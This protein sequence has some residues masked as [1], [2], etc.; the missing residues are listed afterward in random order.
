MSKSAH[1]N[2][3]KNSCDDMKSTPATQ[4]GDF[5]LK[6]KHLLRLA[7][8]KTKLLKPNWF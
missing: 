6:T 3:N 7:R 8:R 5:G 4:E 1:A 2:S